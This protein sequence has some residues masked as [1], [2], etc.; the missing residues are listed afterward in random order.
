MAS[1]T[2][3]WVDETG[4]HAPTFD[5]IMAYLQGQVRAIFGSDVYLGNDSQDQQ[6]LGILATAYYDT[7]SATIAVYNNFSPATALGVGLSSMVK[8]NGLARKLP[9]NSTVDLT[10]I[11]VPGTVII[12]GA[13][14][15]TNQNFRWLLPSPVT[16]PSTGAA[17][18]TATAEQKGLI[19]AVM[20][21]ITRIATPTFGW[22]TVTND[23][24]ANPGEPLESD[25]DLRSRQ[26]VST[27]LASVTALDGMT[28]SVLDITGVT[29]T[30]VIE[31][32]TSA[33]NPFGV[34]SHS[35]CYVVEGGD[36]TQ[37]GTAIAR[38]KTPGAGT[39]G[40]APGD[41]NTIT[42]QIP[43]QWNIPHPISFRRPRY[44]T[45]F[46]EIQ[47]QVEINGPYN[48]GIGDTIIN[49]VVNYLN[50]RPIGQTVFYT[51][52]VGAIMALPPAL[53]NSFNL[54]T[55]LTGRALPVTTAQD[56]TM[57]FDET[58]SARYGQPPGG[59]VWLR[60]NNTSLYP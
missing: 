52:L 15:D 33:T 58:T 31:N 8:I 1:P 48:S 19:R 40:G 30:T 13:A 14:T 42:V 7:N 51:R 25:V 9:T 12:N 38:H 29:R 41:P 5:A 10:V 46:C 56:L 21:T 60:I 4:I 44:A 22:Q 32:D 43:D 18:V 17:I 55:I 11:G 16:I 3:C 49:A 59:T 53:V 39:Y 20:H 26:T 50:D 24:D 27:M 36:A 37:I 45:I 57:G 23:V 34:P 35:V 6:I 54:M 28:G 2:S 47:I